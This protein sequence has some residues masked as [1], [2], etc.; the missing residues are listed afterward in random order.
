MHNKE[1]GGSCKSQTK[2]QKAW[3][4]VTFYYNISQFIIILTVHDF[5]CLQKK[6]H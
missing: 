4:A 2:K 3:I 5:N 1:V 6:K